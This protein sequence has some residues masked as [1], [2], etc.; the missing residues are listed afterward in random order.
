MLKIYDSHHIPTNRHRVGA[1]ACRP[2]TGFFLVHRE[3]RR[4]S[5]EK[6]YLTGR[7]L[8]F[9]WLV[10]QWHEHEVRSGYVAN[11]RFQ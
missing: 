10:R 11:E 8:R 9:E 5:L 3:A 2:N 7:R 6:I 1:M 4:V